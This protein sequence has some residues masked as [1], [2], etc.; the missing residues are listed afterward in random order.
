[1]AITHVFKGRSDIYGTFAYIEDNELVVGENTSKGA[2]YLFSGSIREF[3]YSDIMLIVNNRNPE[4][5]ADIYEYHWRNTFN[6]IIDKPEEHMKK[7]KKIC[8]LKV[9]RKDSLQELCY[10]LTANGYAVQ[11]AVVWKEFPNT[12]ID[13]WQIAICEEEEKK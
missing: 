9:D 1:M 6:N 8:E 12:G 13:H 2:E 11:T 3:G 4:L 5:V 10:H 7:Y